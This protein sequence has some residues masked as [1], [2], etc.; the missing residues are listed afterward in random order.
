MDTQKIFMVRAE[1]EVKKK[2]KK[3]KEPEI[4]ESSVKK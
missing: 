4:M 3:K 1:E 2:E